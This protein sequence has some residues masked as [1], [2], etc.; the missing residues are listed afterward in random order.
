M[1]YCAINEPSRIY[2]K[3]FTQRWTSRQSH[4]VGFC[5]KIKRIDRTTWISFC[6]FNF[7]YRIANVY[8]Y[9]CISCSIKFSRR[10]SQKRSFPFVAPLM[11]VLIALI[12]RDLPPHISTAQLPCYSRSFAI[13]VFQEYRGFRRY[14]IDRPQFCQVHYNKYRRTSTCNSFISRWE[15]PT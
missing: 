7:K 6:S 2:E 10:H 11:T 1:F 14:S 3:N 8:I 13:F 5:H 15:I 9:M 4:F 12:N